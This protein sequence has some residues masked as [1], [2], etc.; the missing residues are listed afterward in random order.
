[1]KIHHIGIAVGSLGAA[2]PVFEKMLGKPADAEEVVEEQKVRVAMFKVGESRLELLEATSE[3][4]PLARSIAKRGEGLHHIALAVEDL[5]ATL[6]ELE[7]AG[8]RLIDRE[9]RRGA[10]N[11]LVAF[12]HPAS[13]AGVLIELVEDK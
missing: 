12:L 1:M 13:T 4:S 10:G 3:D 7:N 11:E 9:P 8:V 5:A 2:R 6:R